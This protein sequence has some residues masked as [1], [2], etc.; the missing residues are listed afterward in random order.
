MGIAEQPFDGHVLRERCAAAGPHRAGSDGDG[1][2]SSRRFR[3][4][5]A[6]HRRVTWTLKMVDQIINTCGETVS[7]DLHRCDLSPQSRQAFAEASTQM[8]E[9][10]ALEMR[11]RARHRCAANS[12]RD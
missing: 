6:Q 4:E 2:L 12:D 3:F 11:R 9:S 8:L 1:N 7:I 10:S 5:H